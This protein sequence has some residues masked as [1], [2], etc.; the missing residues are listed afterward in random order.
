MLP[1]KPEDLDPFVVS[2][3]QR[4]GVAP[5]AAQFVLGGY[6]ALKH[7]LDYRATADVDAW[8]LEREDHKALDV[9]RSAFTATAEQYGFSVR[10]RA[11]GE[12][13][14]LEAFNGDNKVFSFQVAV[15]SVAIDSPLDSP[16]G[17]FKI[18]TLDDNLA[19][20]MVALVARGA[21]RDFVDVKTAVDKGFASITHCW[22]LWV[23]KNRD[24][25]IEDAIGRVLTHLARIESRIPLQDVPQ[26]RR[27]QAAALRAWYREEFANLPSVLRHLNFSGKENSAS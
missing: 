27:T 22:Q 5:E 10:E 25:D 24:A 23:Q 8:W 7:Y 3:L 9:A 1:R 17:H 11:W 13:H 6:F 19:S 14:S 15:R 2:F 20:K 18:E 21:P 26:D 4:L 12:T 16:W